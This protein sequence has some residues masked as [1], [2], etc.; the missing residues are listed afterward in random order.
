MDASFLKK[1]VHENDVITL[2][3][4]R[5][6]HNWVFFAASSGAPFI[7]QISVESPALILKRP[8]NLAAKR[9]QVAERR[10]AEES[11]SQ[12]LPPAIVW[13]Q[14]IKI[15]IVS[16]CFW[17]TKYIVAVLQI[18]IFHIN[19]KSIS[20]WVRVGV[21]QKKESWN[22]FTK[23]LKQCW[24]EQ[25]IDVLL[26]WYFLSLSLFGSCLLGWRGLF[27]TPFPSPV[28]AFA[29]LEGGPGT[30]RRNFYW[31]RCHQYPMG[32]FNNFLE[33]WGNYLPKLWWRFWL[34]LD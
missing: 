25:N 20:T 3:K 12:Y 32:F 17:S 18:N 16:S 31:P 1:R 21:C 24:T 2:V 13:I 23:I 11:I 19:F 22:W 28:R 29:T 26:Q 15:L 7:T 30:G 33:T 5:K 8:S 27:M 9:Q 4:R 34:G 6:Y 10:I 14:Y